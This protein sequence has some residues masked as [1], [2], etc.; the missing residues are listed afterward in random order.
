[1]NVISIVLKNSEN[2]T[3]KITQNEL[4]IFFK[5]AYYIN[6]RRKTVKKLVSNAKICILLALVILKI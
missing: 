5:K 2:K 6:N 4:F 3:K 1:M